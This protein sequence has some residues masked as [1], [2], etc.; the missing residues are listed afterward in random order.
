MNRKDSVIIKKVFMKTFVV[1]LLGVGIQSFFKDAK[2]M[3]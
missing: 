2:M 1:N 3:L